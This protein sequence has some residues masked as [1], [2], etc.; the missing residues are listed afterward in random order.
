MGHPVTTNPLIIMMINMT[1]VFFVLIALSGLIHL[2]HMVDPTKII[3]P[4]PT[5]KA[6]K[7]LSFQNAWSETENA[8]TN[9][10]IRPSLNLNYSI[11]QSIPTPAGVAICNSDRF[12]LP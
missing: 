12:D 7:P 3:I 4:F 1:V 6:E 10:K 5:V 9:S 2:I 8:F 11:V